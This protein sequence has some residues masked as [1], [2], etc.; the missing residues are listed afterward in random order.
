VEGDLYMVIDYDVLCKIDDELNEDSIE[1]LKVWWVDKSLLL[2]D[3]D[4]I[5]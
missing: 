2:V 1:E 3:V 5:E 4:E